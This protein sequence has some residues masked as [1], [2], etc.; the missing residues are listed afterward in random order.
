MVRKRV[1]PVRKFYDSEIETSAEYLTKPDQE[2]LEIEMEKG[3][4]KTSRK[5]FQ[6]G[7]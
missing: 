2:Q 6:R 7:I 4:I 3:L 1:A 5:R